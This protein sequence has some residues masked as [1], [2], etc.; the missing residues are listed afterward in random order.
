MNDGNPLF[1]SAVADV[2][3]IADWNRTGR[4]ERKARSQV[5]AYDTQF[6]GAR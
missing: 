1:L 3:K 5:L 6:E 2:T 4:P